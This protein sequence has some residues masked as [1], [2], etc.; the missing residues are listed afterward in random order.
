MLYYIVSVFFLLFVWCPS[1]A[2]NVKCS[3][4][5]PGFILLTQYYYQRGA[6]LN[7]MKRFCICTA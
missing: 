7:A 4:F 6:R 1:L 2:I 3:G 5:L